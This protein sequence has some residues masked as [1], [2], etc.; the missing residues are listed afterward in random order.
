MKQ[1]RGA[2]LLFTFIV[3]VALAVLVGSFLLMVS[4]QTL[5]SGGGLTGA[6]ALWVAEAGIQH[7][8]YNL[9]SDGS[10]RTNPTTVTGSVGEGTYSVTVSRNNSTYTLASTGTVGE[11]SRQV[12][13]TIVVTPSAFDY[14]VFGNTNTNELKIENTVV[15]SGD[16]YYDGDV[17][18]KANASVING[19]VYADN[20][21]GAGTYTAAPGPPDP[22]PEYP[23]FDTTWYDN[24]IATAESEATDDLVLQGSSTLSLNGATVYYKSAT[25]QGTASLLGP[26]TLVTTGDVDIKNSAAL[27]SNISI[28]SRDKVKMQNNATILSGTLVFA[29]DGITLQNNASMEAG[30]ILVPTSGKEV[31]LKDNT[32]MAGAVYTNVADLQNDAIITGS[33]VASEFAS[34]KIQNNVRITYDESVLGSIPTGMEGA[35]VTLRP[36]KDWDEVAP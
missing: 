13:Q 12:T 1:E 28:I 11:L 15:I 24:E 31:K 7:T 19:L 36:Q 3:M 16:L 20:V 10:F 29:R 2:I 5:G 21:T 4:T 18:V 33:V 26:G 9:R 34:N 30:N 22:V 23:P 14:A 8:F 17:Q 27:T 25:I 6:Q 35:S 32:L